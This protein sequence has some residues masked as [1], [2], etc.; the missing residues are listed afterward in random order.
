MKSVLVSVIVLLVAA[1]QA[2][3]VTIYQAFDNDPAWSTYVG[4]ASGTAYSYNT[5]GWVNAAV[6]RKKDT[7]SVCD[8]YMPLGANAIA[9]GTQAGSVPE[10]WMQFDV[11]YNGTGSSAFNGLLGLFNS[12]TTN[13][14]SDVTRNSIAAIVGGNAMTV[15]AWQ[16]TSTGAIAT[17][18]T[19]STYT[20]DTAT[21]AGET[22]RIEMHVY[23]SGGATLLDLTYLKFDNIVIDPLS[24][25][26]TSFTTTTKAYVPGLTLIAA[27]QQ[28]ALGLDAFG[29]RNNQGTDSTGA[30]GSYYFDNMYFSTDQA[31]QGFMELPSWVPEPATMVLFG[32]GGLF[33]S[34]RK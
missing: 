2:P 24:G 27:G 21:T 32:L 4:S 6:R 26:V 13:G 14:S 11:T 28:L 33:L 10:M 17:T 18:P 1:I 9:A 3:A 30:A 23:N 19:F 20:G 7:D 5:S 25:N 34:R 8:Y 22:Y 16:N 31:Y 15:S 12:N 29:F